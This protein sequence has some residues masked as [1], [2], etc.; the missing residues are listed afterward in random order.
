MKGLARDGAGVSFYLVVGTEYAGSMTLQF[1]EVGERFLE[2]YEVVEVLGSGG[3]SRVYG[4]VQ[5]GLDRKV[6][7]KVLAPV[8][9]ESMKD[10]D[11]DRLCRRFE[12][13]AQIVSKLRSPHTMVMYDFGRHDPLLYMILEWI[14]GRTLHD[15]VKQ[16]GALAESRVVRILRQSLASLAEAHE[17]GVLHR[18]IKPQNI[19]VYEHLD[20]PDYVKVLDFGIAKVAGAEKKETQLTGEQAVV[21]TPSYMSPEQILAQEL[22]PP[23][24]IYSLGLVAYE[25]L[26][27]VVAVESE[28]NFSTMAHHLSPEP[29][30]IPPD[31]ML[32]E[33]MRAVLSRMVAKNKDE[34]YQTARDVMDDLSALS[35]GHHTVTNPTFRSDRLKTKADLP[36]S[37]GATPPPM[38]TPE[39]PP[40]RNDRLF[41]AAAVLVVLVGVAFTAVVFLISQMMA[42]DE[43]AAAPTEVAAPAE[44]ASPNAEPATAEP[45]G[46]PS[47]QPREVAEE[48]AVDGS[49]GEV[50]ARELAA[51]E[52]AAAEEKPPREV[53]A[54]EPV[55]RETESMAQSARAE[56]K[57][58]A[59]PETEPSPPPAIEAKPEEPE[60]VEPSA[61]VAV[62]KPV[63]GE[64]EEAEP[65]AAPK[66]FEPVAVPATT[67]PTV[68]P[69][70]ATAKPAS[71]E[72]ERAEKKKKKQ[73][74]K[75]KREPGVYSF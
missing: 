43:P 17:M 8:G 39:E 51:E 25:L 70:K 22:G 19:M 7:I 37:H 67:E 36:S 55:T 18:D 16:E 20:N 2:R 71:S 45:A 21:G 57:Q 74:K 40:P 61:S 27:G 5:V 34:R 44:V 28:S 75:K 6:A 35:G 3:M 33:G 30:E 62:E 15:V 66:K 4:A 65:V 24:D 68:R 23:S 48:E 47:I 12:R 38:G 41:A 72:E 64:P 58:R 59:K 32:S 63:D 10:D 60:R 13:E 50:V 73:K 49:S 52:E 46:A 54:N 31:Q 11:F 29:I 53:A 56:K 14:E 69:K 42:P 1:P 9:L 26:F